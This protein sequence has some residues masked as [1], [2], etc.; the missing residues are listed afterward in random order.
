[1][2]SAILSFILSLAFVS[3]LNASNWRQ[4][5]DLTNKAEL[6]I[7]KNQLRPALNYYKQAF[8]LDGVMQWNHHLSNC[9]HLAMETGDTA[10]ARKQLVE[11]LSRGC[12]QNYLNKL[13][14]FY[15]GADR[16]FIQKVISSTPNDTITFNPMWPEIERLFNREQ[17]LRF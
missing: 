16:K 3:A 4:Y 10:F 9:F 2:K 7:C 8:A 14:S 15:Q 13:Q 1:M 6:E 5:Y 17:E 11:I 12:K